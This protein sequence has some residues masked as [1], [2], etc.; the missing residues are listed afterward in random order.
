MHRE[1]ALEVDGVFG[2]DVAAARIAAAEDA[3]RGLHRLQGRLAGFDEDVDELDEV[4]AFFGEVDGANAQG[5]PAQAREVH[6][7]GDQLGE[8]GQALLSGRGARRAETE[9]LEVRL[10][11][12][13]VERR[14]AVDEDLV[15]GELRD[16]LLA[17][18]GLAAHADAGGR[19]GGLGAEV[20][21]DDDLDGLVEE[22]IDALGEPRRGLLGGE[23]EELVVVLSGGLVERGRRLHQA[24][25]RLP[26]REGRARES[27]SRTSVELSGDPVILRRLT[28]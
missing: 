24:L 27:P 18:A 8:G 2:E 17:E 10:V 22:A 25:S 19:R 5:D 14:E 13:P 11:R 23:R 28:R 9:R 20:V 21:V 1:E 16:V 4:G 3:H 7:A 26:V 12:T 15:L 6:R